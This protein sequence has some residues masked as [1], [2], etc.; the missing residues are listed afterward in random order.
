[1]YPALIGGF[2][3]TVLVALVVFL[4]PVFE[5][6]LQGLRRRPAR[7]HQVH[8]RRCRT[9]SPASGTSVIGVAVGI[10]FAFKKWKAHRCA[11]ASS[12]TA[13]SFVSRGRS[14]HRAEG[15]PG[16]LLAHLLGAD[17]R[18][19][20][21]A[22]GDRDHRQDRRHRPPRRLA[23][24]GSQATGESGQ[25]RLITQSIDANADEPALLSLRAGDQLALAVTSDRFVEI[26]IPELGLFD[27]ATP[28][29][30]ARFNLIADEPGRIVVRTVKPERVVAQIN[31]AEPAE[32]RSVP[33]GSDPRGTEQP[34][35]LRP[36]SGHQAKLISQPLSSLART[37]SF[38]IRSPR[39]ALT[40]RSVPIAAAFI[41]A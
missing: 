32:P 40:S 20:P 13:S 36:L 8:G 22:P 19:R 9:S 27:T 2:A 31:I 30:P 15:L 34:E 18:R 11:A 5:K 14:A 26:E 37:L 17:R 12:G 38:S 1:M 23:R 39:S 33:E 35:G 6:H 25:N 41:S 4:V 24:R 16:A 21:D 29:S 3:V 7:D 28:G 10:V